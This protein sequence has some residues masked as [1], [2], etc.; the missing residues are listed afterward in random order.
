MLKIKGIFCFISLLLFLSLDIFAGPFDDFKQYFQQN[1]FK[2]FVKD[3]GGVL[4]ANDFSSGRALGFPGFDIGFNLAI[5]KEPSSN[6]RILKDADVKSFGIPII[7]ASVGLP[8]TGLD[9][10]LRGF[11]YSNLK[12]I[13]AGL[14][15]N[16][17]KSGMFTKFM[18]DLSSVVYYDKIDFNYFKGNHL[19]FNIVAS[20]DIPVIKPFIG[21]GIDKTKLETKNLGFG[22]DGIDETSTKTRYTMGLRF[23]PLPLVYVYGAYSIIHS[24]T[25]YNLGLGVRF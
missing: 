12:I 6:N 7:H 16:I 18:P 20:W 24:E 4:G 17:F 9:V 2:A 15:Y 19:S 22:L 3:F 10:I 23:C 21:A 1:Y 11:S 14:R 5:Q 25:G 8:F 13:G